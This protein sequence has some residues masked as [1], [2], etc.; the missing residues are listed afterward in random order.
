MC[1]ISTRAAGEDRKMKKEK[2]ILDMCVVP[3]ALGCKRIKKRKGK[4]KRKRKRKRKQNLGFVICLNP[5][6][7]L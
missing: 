3:S 7:Q 5:K 2:T 6:P 1:G 4:R